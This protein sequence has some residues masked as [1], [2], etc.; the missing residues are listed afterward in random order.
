MSEHTTRIRTK[1]HL[2]PLTGK[3]VS[4]SLRQGAFSPCERRYCLKAT[5][6]SAASANGTPFERAADSK[7]F[8]GNVRAQDMQASFMT[9][10]RV[11][12]GGKKERNHPHGAATNKHPNPPLK[13]ETLEDGLRDRFSFGRFLRSVVLLRPF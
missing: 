13:K 12:E 2:F 5:G 1:Y 7:R 3:P 4:R 6:S 11:G 10:A 8:C 9:G